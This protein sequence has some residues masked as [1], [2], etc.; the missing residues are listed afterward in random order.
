M[1]YQNH[2]SLRLGAIWDRENPQIVA[3][4]VDL[5]GYDS[6]RRSRDPQTISRGSRFQSKSR[7]LG[8]QVQF[9]AIA[10]RAGGANETLAA[11]LPQTGTQRDAIR[12][13]IAGG[14]GA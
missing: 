12:V 4:T 1:Q 2:L 7:N 6:Q 8:G 9:A 10:L 11:I 13:C 5:I 3:A 14:V